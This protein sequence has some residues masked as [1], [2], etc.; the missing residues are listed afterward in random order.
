MA[1]K[2]SREKINIFTLRVGAEVIVCPTN[3]APDDPRSYSV[4]RKLN[5][6]IPNSIYPDQYDNPSTQRHTTWQRAEIWNKQ[7]E[8][9]RIMLP[10]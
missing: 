1:D 7:K 9:S 8:R 5:K 3:V 6:E 10:R 2:R 4:A